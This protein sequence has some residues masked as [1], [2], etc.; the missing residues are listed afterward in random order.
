ML[1]TS[2]HGHH[3]EQVD[4]VFA[5][6][7]IPSR[8]TAAWVD[9]VANTEALR[10]RFLEK[11]GAWSGVPFEKAI[12]EVEL[13]MDPPE[14]WEAWLAADRARPL[15][16]SE[17]LPWRA[18][19]WPRARRFI[20]TFHHALLDGR[21]ITRVLKCFF[22]RIEGEN[23]GSLKLARW[24]PASGG[25][26][27]FDR[28]EHPMPAVG[29]VPPAQGI[30]V[31]HLGEDFLARLRC[32][33][34]SMKVTVPTLVIWSWGQAL[35]RESGGDQV[36]VD[37]LR[38]GV[39]QPGT[40]GFTMNALPIQMTRSGR[41]NAFEALQVFREQLLNLRAFENTFTDCISSS[42]IMVE[43]GT[44]AHE[45]SRPFIESV[46][47]HEA[48]GEALG[49]TAHVLPDLR[50]EVEGPERHRLLGSWIRVLEDQI[51]GV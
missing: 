22:A 42:I 3:V 10:L 37:Q 28:L 43:H 40:A 2:G 30:A 44:V 32:H 34:V 14:S 21:S 4:V 48:C 5:P 1:G 12:V 8:I 23:P 35:A 29:Q 45:L 47:L 49:A 16:A 26:K 36:V 11:D 38:A 41:E 18:V 6:E 15:L 25:A 20:W 31:C 50:L 33:A 7:V 27:D 51:D 17:V 19:F 46:K 24:H 9:T 13:E 39:P